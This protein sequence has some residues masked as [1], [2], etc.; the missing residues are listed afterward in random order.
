MYATDGRPSRRSKADRV[1]LDPSQQPTASASPEAVSGPVARIKPAPKSTPTRASGRSGRAER[2]HKPRRSTA[3][4]Q[5]RAE[6]RV[7]LA[8]GMIDAIA[9]DGYRATRVADVIAHAGVS[10]KT[11]YEHFE[12]KEECLLVTCDLITAEA[13][14]RVE[15]AYREAEGWPGRVEAAILALFDAAIDNPGAL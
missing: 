9:Q 15:A 14:R 4:R 5:A 3:R 1:T 13:M 7:R 6:Q 11:F 8:L 10:R 12:N 2:P